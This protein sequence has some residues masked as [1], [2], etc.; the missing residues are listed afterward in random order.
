MGGVSAVKIRARVLRAMIE[1]GDASPSLLRQ[2]ADDAQCNVE[3]VAEQLGRLHA[4]GLA[5][6]YEPDATEPSTPTEEHD[7][8]EG[9]ELAPKAMDVICSLASIAM[10]RGR[11]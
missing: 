6:Y 11:A 9:W 3:Q 1:M 4:A 2:L 8:E 10:D 5:I 7:E